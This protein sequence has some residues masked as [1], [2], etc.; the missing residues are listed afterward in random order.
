MMFLIMLPMH[1]LGW[2][3][4]LGIFLV[5]FLVG[6]VWGFARLIKFDRLP[7]SNKNLR[8][9]VLLALSLL[10]VIVTAALQHPIEDLSVSTENPDPSVAVYVELG[11]KTYFYLSFVS[12]ILASLGLVLISIKRFRSAD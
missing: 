8:L 11:K 1:L 3:F 12:A 10:P 7:F 6:L 5:P 9:L 4:S 2:F